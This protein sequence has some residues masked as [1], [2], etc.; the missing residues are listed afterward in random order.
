[1]PDEAKLI[2]PAQGYLLSYLEACREYKLSPSDDGFFHDND[3]FMDWKDTI[4]KTYENS[5]LG[6]GLKK[7]YVP[8]TTFW[9]VE[10]SEFI[11]Y[12]NVRHYLTP[13]LERFGG[14][15]GYVIRPSRQG[16]GYGAKQ[17]ALLLNEAAWLNIDDALITCNDNNIA[18]I[19]IIEKNNGRYLDTIK[20][21]IGG[22][23]RVTRR[24]WVKTFKNI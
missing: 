12:G 23:E 20:N 14:H 19:R 24:Y 2:L 8:A 11:G 4:F 10:N 18:S 17:L 13:P 16:M 22:K 6:I 1:M 7:G 21:I 3:T 15:I 5:S 9:L